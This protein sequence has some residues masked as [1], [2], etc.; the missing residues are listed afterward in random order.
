ME[1][2]KIKLKRLTILHLKMVYADQDPNTRLL[3]QKSKQY[4]F[5]CRGNKWLF[6]DFSDIALCLWIV[7]P[8]VMGF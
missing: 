4:E 2:S 7:P 8:E 5:C 3:L 6:S 1:N